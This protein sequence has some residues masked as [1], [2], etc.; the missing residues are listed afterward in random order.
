MEILWKKP[1]QA[2]GNRA[3]NLSFYLFH[4][5]ARRGGYFHCISK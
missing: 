3:Y 5:A 1:E 2:H 4:E